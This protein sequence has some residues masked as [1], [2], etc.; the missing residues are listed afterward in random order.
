MNPAEEAR[1]PLNSASVQNTKQTVLELLGRAGVFG[2]EAAMLVALV[3]AGALTEAHGELGK[4]GVELPEGRGG[5]YAD[6]WSD[7]A[8]AAGAALGRLAD[9]LLQEATATGPHGGSRAD[10]RPLP[11]VGFVDVERAKVAVTPLYLVFAHA[12]DFDPEESD[13]VLTA[14]LGTMS[15]LERAGYAGRLDEF[16]RAHG[17]R[18][19]QLYADYGPGSA[20]GIH[21][22]YSLAHSPS[23]IAVLERLSTAPEELRAA[24]DSAELPPAWLEG[25]AK[26]WGDAPAA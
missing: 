13:R 8:H 2:D 10:G 3:E 25:L 23:G 9:R 26:A 14:V 11:P 19:T 1:H 6:G 18:L 17:E 16:T 15:A 12:S 20:V 24:W 5:E 4:T 21:S 7:G 22:R